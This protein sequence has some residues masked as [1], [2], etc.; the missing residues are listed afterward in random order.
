M[1]AA[2]AVT[3][4]LSRY[5][6][7]NDNVNCVIRNVKPI[8]EMTPKELD[9]LLESIKSL[10]GKLG[11][12]QPPRVELLEYLG[13]S[14]SR[15]YRAER[16][17]SGVMN[18]S[19]GG[20]GIQNIGLESIWASG[21][22]TV[23]TRLRVRVVG[24]NAKSVN[25]V[26][27]A[28]DFPPEVSDLFKY[29]VRPFRQQTDGS[30]LCLSVMDDEEFT[31]WS[32][33][34]YESYEPHSQK[35][36]VKLGETKELEVKL[37]P[38]AANTGRA[39][40]QNLLPQPESENK[41]VAVAEKSS[42]ENAVILA[43]VCRD[44][45]GRALPGV[46]LTL[47]G[48]DED[49]RLNERLQS[50]RSDAVGQFRFAPV[51][52]RTE[53]HSRKTYLVCAAAQ[54]RATEILTYNPPISRNVDQLKITMLE[55]GS[56][57]GKITGPDGRPVAGAKVWTSMSLGPDQGINTATSNAEGEYE[58]ADL[59]RRDGNPIPVSGQPG[60]FILSSPII[61]FSHPRFATV[62]TFYS[63]VPSTIDVKLQTP[64]MIEGRVVYGDS[65]K[66]AAGIRLTAAPAPSTRDHL[67]TW[68]PRLPAAMP[69]RMRT[70]DI[71]STPWLQENTRFTRCERTTMQT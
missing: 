49:T 57:R 13:N 20:D 62:C 55:S 17:S 11:L 16:P 5:W 54:G 3:T 15:I 48:E 50:T 8:S 10:I 18:G 35:L 24:D 70:A 67:K 21:P 52:E 38:D 36:K 6:L 69:S 40:Q 14:W 26:A 22:T 39:S 60:S 28:I 31:L 19:V 29:H 7:G 44:D 63:Q 71:A 51:A 66:P 53:K 43:G 9:G 33:R 61:C 59:A 56:I 37:K 32:V 42:P 64:A 65:N 68:P 47:F 23:H 25:N 45:Q 12:H 27:F 46:Q 1:L 41:K 58:I 2:Y 34:V 4:P 30:W